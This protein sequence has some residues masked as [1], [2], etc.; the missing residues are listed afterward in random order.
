MAR[1]LTI[2]F[3]ATILFSCTERRQN[4]ELP[5]HIKALRVDHPLET[6]WLFST[7]P[8]GDDLKPAEAWREDIY[9]YTDARAGD[10]SIRFTVTEE[11]ELIG[12]TPGPSTPQWNLNSYDA[13]AMWFKAEG[14]SIENGWSL[15]MADKAGK[16]ASAKMEDIGTSG[17]WQELKIP[18]T[19]LNKEEGFNFDGISSLQMEVH[20]KAGSSLWFDDVRFTSA[21]NPELIL[22]ISDKTIN[23]R[24]LEAEESRERRVEAGFEHKVME[25]NDKTLEKQFAKLWLGQDIPEVNGKLY[26]LFTLDINDPLAE[27]HN[28]WSLSLNPMLIR[29]YFNFGSKSSIKPG[30]LFPETEKLLLELLWDRMKDMNDI[31]I[32]RQ[33]TWWII[34]SENHDINAKAAALL[35]SQIFMNEPDFADRIYPDKGTGG[36]ISYWFHQMYGQGRNVAGPE[37]NGRRS[38]E[39]EYLASD[40][41]HAWIRFW[42]EYIRE[43]AGKGFFLEVASSGYMGHTL[44]FFQNIYDFSDDPELKKLAGMFLDLVWAEWAQDQLGGVRGGAKTRWNRY[45]G[46]DAMW[47]QAVF[48]LGGPANS[49]STPYWQMASDYQWPEIVWRM[50]LDRKGKGEYAY[51]SRKPGEEEA[52]L[53]PRP[54]GLERTLACDAE[55][56]FVRY[57]WVTPD[58]ILGTQMDHPAA[59]HSHL[60]TATRWQ[61]MSFSSNF[62]STVSPCGVLAKDTGSWKRDKHTYYR[63]IQDKNI[64]ITQ[65]CRRWFQ[66]NPDW[67]PTYDIYDREFGIWFD[68]KFD[69]VEEEEGWIFVEQGDA[70]LALRPLMGEYEYDYVSWV[71][72]GNENLFSI[73][74]E[75]T[76][77]WGP[78][79]QFIQFKDRYSPIV[80]EA[81]RRTDFPTIEEFQSHILAKQLGLKKTV[82]PGWYIVVY[83]EGTEESPQIYFNASNNEIPKI[84]GVHMDYAPAITF[85]SPFISSEYKSG[86][87]N[88]EVDGMK[89][90][91]DFNNPR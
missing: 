25:G 75:D 80:M 52:G 28:K 5:D 89:E 54:G 17:Y 82:V 57:S 21:G 22:G 16:H 90:V 88:I 67:Y 74:R 18:F 56:R 27:V 62:T 29:M 49:G 64:L 8:A 77:D 51:I 61:G 59:V 69:R 14:Q 7:A 1:Y 68:G 71:G 46:Y 78:D 47:K 87:I 43:R 9:D 63:S 38:D 48:Y 40:H 23:Q 91:W 76:Y 84:N 20:M 60:S 34:G 53:W 73:M 44:N 26:E 11:Q 45:N 30:R 10:F 83:G 39:G 72:T 42:K 66:Q 81:G 13:L 55:A 41:Y 19:S 79:R 6:G 24:L 58:Y 35:S 32:A 31:H 85:E 15:V 37:G 70:Y 2:I 86:M 33:S 4:T 65:Q 50:V 12:F 3:A 36:G